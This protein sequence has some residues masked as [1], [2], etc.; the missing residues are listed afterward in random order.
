[1]PQAPLRPKVTVH[2]INSNCTAH[3]QY[4]CELLQGRDRKGRERCIC[5]SLVVHDGTGE[6]TS[7]DLLNP[8]LVITVLG[9]AVIQS[10]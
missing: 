6:K 8:A 2:K 1:M 7:S 5:P 10:I 3:Y 4:V 9:R